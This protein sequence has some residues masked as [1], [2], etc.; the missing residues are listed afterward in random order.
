MEIILSIVS[1]ALGAGG[2]VYAWMTNR[3][4]A[5]LERLMRSQLRGLAGNVVNTRKNPGWADCHFRNIQDTALR[6]DRNDHLNHILE[7]AQTGARDATAAERMLQNLLN[8]LLSLQDGLFGT[9]L[10]EHSNL[11]E[12]ASASGKPD[13]GNGQ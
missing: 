11:K 1:V 7:E 12:R 3:E 2:L 4:K 6:L 13:A 9:K 10:I 5:N 8:E